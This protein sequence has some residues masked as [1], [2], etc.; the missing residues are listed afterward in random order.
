MSVETRDE[1]WTR[2]DVTLH[3]PVQLDDAGQQTVVVSL[4]A[5]RLLLVDAGFV[6]SEPTR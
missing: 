6:M 1:Y 2:N 4:E 5:M 3:V